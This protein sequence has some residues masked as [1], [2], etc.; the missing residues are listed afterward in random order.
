M[1]ENQGESDNGRSLPQGACAGAPATARE[2]WR[3]WFSQGHVFRDKCT[4]LCQL[5]LY[6]SLLE[7]RI[8]VPTVG[9]HRGL[10]FG[11]LL[12]SSLNVLYVLESIV[13][14]LPCSLFL[15]LLLGAVKTW[16]DIIML[17]ASRKGG[18][19]RLAEGCDVV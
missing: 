6:A 1:F 19:V 13:T 3:L 9:A 18:S 15:I 10:C 11:M 7:Q 14:L 4:H 17:S 12:A 2:V 16:I 5:W 8:D